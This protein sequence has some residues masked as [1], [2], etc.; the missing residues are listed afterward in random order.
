MWPFKKRKSRK[1]HVFII[2]GIRYDIH[3]MRSLGIKGGYKQDYKLRGVYVSKNG[4]VFLKIRKHDL[5]TMMSY[6]YDGMCT[7]AELVKASNEELPKL[8]EAFQ[9]QE[10]LDRFKEMCKD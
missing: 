4:T 3:D 9:C 7:P 1:Q 6:E 5:G 10:L 2:N 8:A